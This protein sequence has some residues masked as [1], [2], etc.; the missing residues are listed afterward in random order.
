MSPKINI[1]VGSYVRIK[2]QTTIGQVV[3]INKQKALV[4]TDSFHICLP[5]K[6]IEMVMLKYNGI[7]KKKNKYNQAN[8]Y[9]LTRPTQ[10]KDPV[11]DLHGC[12]SA[13]A[14]YELE[15]FIDRA[16]LSGHSQLKIIHGKGSGILRNVVRNY[17]RQ[18]HLIRR[19]VENSPMHCKDGVTIA[20]I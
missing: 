4:S 18:H 5:I 10:L 19:V 11:L 14:Q 3:R 9:R 2:D 1:T 6:D 17:L 16:L 7:P 20:E 13:Q 12:N 15:K 8:G